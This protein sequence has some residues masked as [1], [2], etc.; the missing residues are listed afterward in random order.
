MSF[1]GKLYNIYSFEG[2]LELAPLL[3]DQTYLSQLVLIRGLNSLSKEELVQFSKLIGQ[4]YNDD[5][6]FISWDFGQVME[7]KEDSN[8][9][10]YLFSTEAVPYHWDGAFH[11]EPGILV[12]NC[13]EGLGSKAGRTLFANTKKIIS[14]KQ[15][16]DIEY[17]SKQKIEYKTE[18]LAHYGGSILREVVSNHPVTGEQVLRFGEEVETKLN[19]VERIINDSRTEKLIKE[20]EIDLYDPKYSYAHD[21]Q[22]GDLLLADNH[23]LL[24]G[25]ESF[26]SKEK[27]TRH[28]RRIQVR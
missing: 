3:E 1:F 24:H 6:K 13:I 26:T 12:F 17:L 16:A 28:L 25:R 19:P 5:N 4:K 11:E 15:A 18:K 7:L 14:D 10:N 9:K 8:A 20:M 2:L 27:A 22:A 23:G 21:W